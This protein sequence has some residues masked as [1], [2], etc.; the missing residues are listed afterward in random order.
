[1]DKMLVDYSEGAGSAMAE[2]EKSAN[3]LNGTLNKL[4]NTWTELVNTFV[5]T[6][7]L[8]GAVNVLNNILQSVT[9]IVDKLKMSGTIGLGAGLF[10]G[11][12]N[13][14][15][16]KSIQSEDDNGVENAKIVTSLQARR[17]VQE[18]LNASIARQAAQLEIDHCCTTGL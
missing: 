11:I 14:G 9:G 17:I 16:F 10:A 3:N 13:I 18:E 8:K 12:K 2:S 5:N 6:D 15:I 4:S 7:G 1:M